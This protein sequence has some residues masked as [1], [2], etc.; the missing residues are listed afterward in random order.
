MTNRSLR[1]ERSE[2]VGTDLNYKCTYEEPAAQIF[3][4]GSSCSSSIS[5]PLGPRGT[6]RYACDLSYR[7]AL[8]ESAF[9]SF[10]RERV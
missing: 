8:S 4:S 5:S 2:A 3:I 1:S 6:Y 7:R 9:P 10:Q